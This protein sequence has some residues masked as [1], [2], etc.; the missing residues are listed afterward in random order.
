MILFCSTVWE[1]PE[2][3]LQISEHWGAAVP[4]KGTLQMWETPRVQAD[5]AE[6]NMKQQFKGFILCYEG[7][8][9]LY[10]GL[11]WFQQGPSRGAQW[12]GAD[13]QCGSGASE[14]GHSCAERWE[15]QLKGCAQRCQ[16]V[17][18]G[19]QVVDL[20]YAACSLSDPLAVPNPAIS[21][22]SPPPDTGISAT[23]ARLETRW[24]LT[25]LLP[26]LRPGQSSLV[27]YMPFLHI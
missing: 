20:I 19:S 22:P 25:L 10:F 26:L 7:D 27:L 15:E 9:A 18:T 5:A 1:L 6:G 16:R 23:S 13:V 11:F 14:T 2:E 12:H 4:C 17:G 3:I 24:G 8:I 21:S